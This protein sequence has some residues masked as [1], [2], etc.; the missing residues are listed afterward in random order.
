MLLFAAAVTGAACGPDLEQPL[1]GYPANGQTV[2]V[3]AID[4]SFN[5]SELTVAAGTTVEW[6]NSGRNDHNVL[7]K[8]DPKASR[9]GVQRSDFGPQ[10][11]YS[12]TFTTPGTYRYYCSIHGNDVRGMVG[13]VTVMAP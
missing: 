2:A 10:D 3:R 12:F 8:G 5:A 9:W 4:N 11:T 1:R 6:I 7:P 13:V